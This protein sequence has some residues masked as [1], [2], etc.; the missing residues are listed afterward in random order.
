MLENQKDPVNDGSSGER[1]EFEVD[2]T[3]LTVRDVI[4]GERMR[5]RADRELELSPA[6]L[7]LFPFPVDRAV[8]FEAAS[9]SVAEYSTVGIRDGDGEYIARPNEP[10]ELRRGSYCV[11][12]TGATKAYI[13]LEDAE[14]STTGI[15]GADPFG[16]TLDRP[17]TVTVGA[18]S[19]HTRPEATI[20]VPD[21]PKALSEAVS[22]L[23]SSIHE[24]S[25]ERSWP[26]LRGHPPRIERGDTLDVPSPLTVPDTGVEVT[27][28]PTYAE[29][30]RLSTLSYYLGARMTIGDAPAIHLDTG[31]T[32]RLPTEG[33]QLEERAEEL[34]STWF[35]LDTLVRTDGYTI[36]DREEYEQVGPLLPF[37]PPNLSGLSMSERLMEYME[38]NPE[39]VAPYTPEWATEAVV[40]PVPATMELLPH[41]AHILA[42]IRVSNSWEQSLSDDC[43]GLMTA[44]RLLSDL[45]DPPRDNNSTQGSKSGSIPQ[46]TSVALPAAYEHELC[47]TP[48]D[49]GD[50]DVVFLVQSDERARLLREALTDPSEP[51]GVRSIS[52][53]GS[54]AVN[55]VADTLSDPSIDLLYC[56][57]PIDDG[58]LVAADGPV[59]ISCLPSAAE[60][61]APSVSIFEGCRRVAAGIESVRRGGTGSAAIDG[62][63]ANDRVRTV[64][65][66]L[67]MKG[68][69]LDTCLAVTGVSRLCSV[70]FV[71]NAATNV[72]VPNPP[73]PHLVFFKSVSESEH[74]AT[75][76]TVFCPPSWLGAEYQALPNYFDGKIRLLGSNPAEEPVVSSQEVADSSSE[77]DTAVFLNGQFVP[78]T[79]GLTPEAVEMS[80]RRALAADDATDSMGL[81][82]AFDNL[83]GCD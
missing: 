76:R 65:E 75:W 45:P 27:V 60:H 61:S 55:A 53:L 83:H 14:L 16:I 47:R 7:E 34:L 13:R 12:I 23:G 11:E 78:S 50:A 52:I 25:P 3:T 77:P 48:P 40:R 22:T 56:D 82:E 39:D 24:F 28:R 43:V 9:L 79:S 62:H 35:F 71:G 1:I 73:S 2:G 72:V 33:D 29:V 37:Y 74:R 66:L 15:K 26:T 70:R 5:L 68:I 49:A 30:Y 69:P 57:L 51:C 67:A 36:S 44:D 17:T 63:I 64:V 59:D 31:Y 8:S 20:T 54:P 58:M 4:E 46:G 38:V 10:I 6:L 42:P 81:G 41:L 21:D 80:A 19:L 32:E 18:R